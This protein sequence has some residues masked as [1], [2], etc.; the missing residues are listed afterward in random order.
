MYLSNVA[1]KNY[2]L[3]QDVKVDLDKKTT[4]VVG[5]N[6][7]GKTSFSN[8]F[9]LFFSDEKPS[10]D[11]F[12]ISSHGLFRSILSKYQEYVAANDDEKPGLLDE[13]IMDIPSIS[14]QVTI[15]YTEAIGE[16][17]AIGELK[18][19]LDENTELVILFEY[20]PKALLP[21]LADLQNISIGTEGENFIKK[22]RNLVV[23]H[24][25]KQ[26]QSISSDSKDPL[27]LDKV[28]KI[29]KVEFIDAQR[30]VD[31]SNSNAAQKLSALLGRYYNRKSQLDEGHLDE[32]QHILNGADDSI[33]IKLGSFFEQFLRG[34][35]DFGYPNLDRVS[36]KVVSQ[37]DQKKMFSNSV[38]LLYQYGTT[39]L[40]EKYNGLGYSN[41]IYILARVREFIEDNSDEGYLRLLFIEEPE[42]HMHPQM[43]GV[44]IKNVE[45]FINSL[46]PTQ[47]TISTH[48][49]TI[50][51]N[52]KDN[53]SRVRYFTNSVNVG[54]ILYT[55]VKNLSKL[56]ASPTDKKFL[57][58]Y[59]QLETCDLFFA[60]KA[61]LLEGVVESILLPLFIMKQSEN[62]EQH[63][64]SEQ[65]VSCSV[66]G[67]AHMKKFKPLVEFLGLKTLIITDIDSV[68][69]ENARWRKKQVTRGNEQRTSNPTLKDWIPQKVLVNDLLDCSDV[70]KVSGNVRV[71]YQT[72][73]NG[74]CGRSF[75]ESFIIENHGFMI[76]N[77][78][79]FPSVIT[80][81]DS[82]EKNLTELLE[83]SYD[84]Q[85]EIHKTDFAYDVLSCSPSNWSVPEYVMEGLEW[86]AQ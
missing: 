56:E 14:L 3:L 66:I 81:L 80:V 40:P 7:T 2:R 53:L 57:A 69:L 75:E 52:C 43:Q 62:G 33:T 47:I 17:A 44:F 31:D 55:E 16:F 1:I 59:L 84:I 50:L 15:V 74:K 58:Q 72:E 38:K 68:Q 12:S 76:D 86:L 6:N 70:N 39:Q 22:L 19:G 34:L 77:G 9:R 79:Y 48:S 51:S 85:N 4:I 78:T 5:K 73:N 32:L 64:L 28:K 41:L 67:G 37:T 42:A 65:Y 36:P 18:P 49:S 10:F 60:D 61:I 26:I 63:K 11:D 54:E 21:F 13:I 46:S 27:T 25:E 30:V 20:K 83:L 8:I 71:A 45:S 29:I 24:Y 82:L 23:I 35:G